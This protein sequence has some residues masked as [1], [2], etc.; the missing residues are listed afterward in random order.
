VAD[1]VLHSAACP[2]L[3]V[4]A[5]GLSKQLAAGVGGSVKACH[6]CGRVLRR[7]YFS[8]EDRCPKCGY[9]LKSCYNCL[10]YA[11]TRCT[12]DRPEALDT[13]PGRHCP[14]FQFRVSAAI[15]R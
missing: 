1:K 5:P 6:N 4:R 3:L 12:I 14:A 10:F 2:V 11:G 15:W 13:Y 9:H 7:E 8:P